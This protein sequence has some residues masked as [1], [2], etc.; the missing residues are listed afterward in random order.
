MP[1]IT[2]SGLGSGLDINGIVEQLVAA[3]GDPKSAKLDAREA[4]LQAQL[5]A[6]GSLK[7]ALS[8]F[9]DQTSNLSL[10]S[11]FRA[12]NSTSSN[13]G[14][15]AATAGTTAV[16]ATYSVEVEQLAQAHSLASAAGLYTSTA[17]VVGTGSLTI[18][19][20][21]TDYDPK[22]D[23]YNGFV[24]DPNAEVLNIQLTSGTNTLADVRD[25]INNAD[26][27]VQASIINDGSGFR[28][29]LTSQ[30]GAASS[31]Q[32]SVVDDDGQNSDTAGLSALAFN[33]TATNLEQTTAGIDANLKLNGIAITSASNR[34][35]SVI[36]GVTLDLFSASPGVPVVVS[37]SRDDAAIEESI[38]SFVS[39]YNELINTMKSLSSFDAESGSAGIL[40]GDSL[41]RGVANAIRREMLSVQNQSSGQFRIL[42]DIGITTTDT[43]ELSVDNTQLNA[44][45]QSDFNSVVSLFS[46]LGV[47]DDSNINY[48]TA[49][50]ATQPGT[51]SVNIS[52]LA[53]AN[54][55][56][57]GS[58]GG[59][60]ASGEGKLLTGSGDA[61]GLVIE[62]NGGALG[63]RGTVVFGR[64]L[65]DRLNTLIGDYLSFD[66]LLSSRTT[67]IEERLSDTADDR[68]ELSE[69]LSVIESR[70]RK[71]FS[72]LDTLIAGMRATSDFL[73]SQ[74]SGLPQ[75]GSG[76]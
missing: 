44:A 60:S 37:V 17:D 18:T 51:Y 48:V 46:P 21:T 31:M 72:A 19:L 15:V 69:R 6:F 47:A 62:V 56:V 30:S 66:G 58:I 53:D 20:G 55:N 50:S 64:G 32:I 23:K 8:S 74:L 3:E 2:T 7:S 22:K 49:S 41:I 13:E 54:G 76:N 33:S 14:I 40:I 59:F 25:A 67:G 43:G 42:A 73:S 1:T 9:G 11:T 39:S 38:G 24:A 65:A 4:Q 70:F 57:Q 12:N 26:G 10:L 36:T 75:I 28:L 61:K 5:S 27:G 63:A 45:L 71:Q 35:D 68:I 16:P 52:N 29:L 34:V